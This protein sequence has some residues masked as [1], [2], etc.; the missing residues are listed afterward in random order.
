MD[1]TALEHVGFVSDLDNGDREALEAV[2]TSEQHPVGTAL[3]VEG[4]DPTKFYVLLDGHVTVHREGS[5]LADLGPGDCFGEMGVVAK[6][7]RNAT[8]IATTPITVA[9]ALGWDLRDQLERNAGLRERLSQAAASR[10]G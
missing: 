8:V 6:E 1:I 10:D 2:F 7:A 9:A 5:H 3:I 4:G